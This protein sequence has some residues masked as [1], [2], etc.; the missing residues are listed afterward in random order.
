LTQKKN[1]R[2]I[3]TGDFVKDESNN[4][5]RSVAG[6]LLVQ[7]KEY[8]ELKY[9]DLK[10]VSDK[11][12]NEKDFDDIS[13]S[14]KVNRYVKSNAIVIVK[15]K[16]MVGVGTGQTSRVKAVQLAVEKAGKKSK[17]AV[18]CSDA[19]FPF[20]DGIDEAAKGGIGTIV[21]PGGSIRDQEVIDAANEHKMVMVFTGIRLFRH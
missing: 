14:Y 11:K 8:P 10:V 2:L 15:D 18:L 5:L 21:H 9:K 6:G 1:L 12:I 16:V 7:S 20:R 19:F 17:G 3:E 4:E 13:F